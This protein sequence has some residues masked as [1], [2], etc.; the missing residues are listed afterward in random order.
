M[1]Y[2]LIYRR[3]LRHLNLGQVAENA[4]PLVSIMPWQQGIF[5]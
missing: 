1:P 2:V 3:V 4:M 5:Y